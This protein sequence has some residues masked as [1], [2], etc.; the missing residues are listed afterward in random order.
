MLP[1]SVGALFDMD[2]VIADTNPY[3]KKAISL[4]CEKHGI[5]VGDDFL[6]E[7]I[8]GYMNE[9]WIPKLFTKELTANEVNILAE[10]KEAIF[11]E[12]YEPYVAPVE[13]L[14]E[15]LSLLKAEN[16]KCVVGTSAPAVNAQFIL[17]K[18][19]L[20]TFFDDVLDSSDVELGKPN[21]EIYLKCAARIGKMPG[22]CIVF[23]DSLA[24]VAAG[25]AAGCKVVGVA[26]THSATELSDTALVIN[27]FEKLTLN[28]LNQLF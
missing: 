11:R 9:E 5:N 7:E 12:L 20:K 28:V 8:Y 10:E 26:T 4:F 23:E 25:N 16:I 19:G 6:K 3:H 17:E 21:P 18:T 2:G 1:N 22:E 24:G 15:F 13:G 27:N 14:R